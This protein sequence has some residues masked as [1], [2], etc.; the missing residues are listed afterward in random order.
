MT[1]L[2]LLPPR[3]YGEN[4]RLFL[5]DGTEVQGVSSITERELQPASFEPGSAMDGTMPFWTTPAVTAIVVELLQPPP[6]GLVGRGVRTVAPKMTG[7]RPTFEV[8]L[9]RAEVKV[10]DREPPR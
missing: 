5:V 9:E 7:L 6:P 10:I 2:Q 4:L 1:T 8:F 3:A